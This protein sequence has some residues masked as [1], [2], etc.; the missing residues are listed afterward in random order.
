MDQSATLVTAVEVDGVRGHAAP[1][2][3]VQ[4][5]WTGAWHAVRAWG[6]GSTLGARVFD[7]RAWLRSALV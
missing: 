3:E 5:E 6:V 1:S 7:S 2:V 4:T